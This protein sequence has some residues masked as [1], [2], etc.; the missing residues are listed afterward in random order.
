MQR[1]D[2]I[3][4]AGVAAITAGASTQA[5]QAHAKEKPEYSWKMVT[6]WPKNFPGLGTGANHLAELIGQMSGGRI[7]VKVYGATELVPAFEVFD[8]VSA[9]TAEMGHGA[10]YYWKGKSEAAQF[11][12]TVPFGLTAQEMNGWLYHGGGMELWREL[13]AK[14]NLVPAPAGNTGVQMAGWFNKEIN[15][16][17]DLKGIK[18]RIPGLGGE[19]LKRAGGTPVNLPGGEIFTSLQSG[20]ID[21]TEWIGP[22]NDLAFGLYKAAKY[23]YYPGWQ[24]PGTTLEAMIH[25]PSFDKLPDDL[26]VIV[27]TACKAI[28]LDMLSEYM[29][30]NPAALDTLVEEHGVDVRPLPADVVARLRGLSGEVVAEIAEQDEFSKRV[31]ASYQKFLK[32]SQAWSKISEYG[33]LTARDHAG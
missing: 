10:A 32:Q 19:V 8:A 26:K 13:Y 1:R 4:A 31:Y 25:K 9:G 3:K 16:L 33:Y 18:M 2:F 28:N 23:Y 24:E 11:F 20:A 22:Y 30:R 14:F 7:E 17:E 21:A 27:M 29:A 12:T 5:G 6:T 15:S